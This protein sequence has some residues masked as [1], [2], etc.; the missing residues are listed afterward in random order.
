MAVPADAERFRALYRRHHPELIAYFARRIGTQDAPD[1]A[2]EVFTV[3]WRRVAHVPEDD[4]A[5][6]WLYGVARNV[7]ANRR[8][9]ARRHDRLLARIWS[10]REPD[11]LGP[12]PQVL[13]HLEGQHV[14][15]ALGS[16]RPADQEL[17]LLSYWEGLTH[18]Q[19]GELLGCSKS[20]VDARVHRVLRRMRQAMRRTGHI[21]RNQAGEAIKEQA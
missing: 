8:R 6:L 10:V 16:L 17:L 7:L 14:I 12:E 18:S 4:E 1:A 21:P 5:L 2:D 9:G 20:A 13:R 3:A 19:I 11:L 15:E